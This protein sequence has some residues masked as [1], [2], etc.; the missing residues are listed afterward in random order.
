MQ[1]SLIYFFI[2]TWSLIYRILPHVGILSQFID[3]NIFVRT[4][5]AN[6]SITH[7]TTTE[8]GSIILG[9]SFY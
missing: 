5:L 3:Q 4:F 8:R 9:I 2:A 1:I 6:M 7:L